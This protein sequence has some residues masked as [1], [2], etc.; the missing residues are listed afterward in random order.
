MEFDELSKRVLG[1]AIEVH[2]NLGPG[3]LEAT[4]AQCLAHEL[5]LNGIGFTAQYPIPVEYK[6][7]RL[8]CG[9]R[10][11]FLVENTLILELK[12]IEKI[13]SVHEAQILTYLKFARVKT[14]L[15]INFN[16]KLLKNGIKRFIM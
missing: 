3:L 10:A 16:V 5:T 2:R 4:Y 12:S 8:E 6:K 1:C 11:D 13:D 7:I 14:G 15:L 9:Y